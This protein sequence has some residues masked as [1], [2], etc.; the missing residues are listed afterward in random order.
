[1]SLRDL[2]IPCA[3]SP[4]RVRGILTAWCCAV[5]IARFTPARAG[6]TFFAFH[7]GRNDLGSPPRVRGI[8]H[9]PARRCRTSR[10]TP[11]RAGNTKAS[12]IGSVTLL[13]SP[14]RVRG[15]L[16]NLSSSVRAIG[17]P[18]RVRG[19]LWAVPFFR[20]YSRFT[21]AR[22][23]NTRD[24]AV[25]TRSL[26]GSPP[27]V[28]G[29]PRQSPSKLNAYRFTPARAGNTLWPMLMFS[30][31]SVHPRACGEYALRRRSHAERRGSPP[32]VRGIHV[33]GHSTFGP[34]RFTPARAGNTEEVVE[35]Q[36]YLYGSPP[37]VRGIR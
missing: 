4:P 17:S 2:L 32:R 11:A 22:A 1:V 19:I 33:V 25:G 10:F 18:P 29:I 36:S 20:F 21:P 5:L 27:R 26:T 23:G 8:R 28:R 6:N 35:E 24:D 9:R 30:Q 31:P 12:L 14:P 16:T 15:I 13:G 37:R 34:R 3:G 7:E